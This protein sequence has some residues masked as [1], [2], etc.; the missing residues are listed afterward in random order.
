MD[1][2]EH[3]QEAVTG[4]YKANDAA[5][6]GIEGNL[7]LPESWQQFFRKRGQE[8]RKQ[9]AEPEPELEKEPEA[10]PDV[11]PEILSR[12]IKRL[13]E[14]EVRL[15]E[16]EEGIE[17]VPEAEVVRKRGL[18]PETFLLKMQLE[19]AHGELRTREGRQ[20]QKS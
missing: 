18:D 9:E 12:I 5:T 17:K 10:E 8:L 14:I 3:L 13:E 4:I 15:D 16:I 11:L 1:G 7:P 19:G 20:W 2:L 6:F